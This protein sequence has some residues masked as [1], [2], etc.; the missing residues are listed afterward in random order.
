MTKAVARLAKAAG[1]KCYTDPFVPDAQS[2][3][4]PGLMT[5]VADWLNDRAA[6]DATAPSRMESMRPTRA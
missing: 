6:G 1:A 3:R 5:R 4:Q 2:A